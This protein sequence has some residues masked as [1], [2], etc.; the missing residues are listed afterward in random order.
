MGEV[1]DVVAR[2]RAE[3][4]RLESAGS[5][6]R[7]FLGTYLRTT[8]AIGAALRRGL[9]EDPA[10]VGRW[11]AVFADYYLAALAA[12]ER[13]PAAVPRPWR[14]AFGT[15]P[16]VHPVG[17]VL[18]GMNAH[19]NFDLPQ[20]TLDAVPVEAFDDPVLMASRHRDHERVD[21]VL[22]EQV[23]REDVALALDD[24]RGRTVVD[25]ALGP[26]NRALVRRFLRESRRR[27][28]ENTEALHRARVRGP[29][30][31]ADAVRDLDTVSSARVADLAR[32]GP[33]L[34]R[35]AVRGFG[36]TLPPS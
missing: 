20:A 21:R 5:H 19:I 14:L 32:P 16:D 34:V 6:L 11:D 2:M 28:W 8:E 30:H 27:T 35:L 17:H 31:Y 29:E 13:D 25:T 1:D 9:F 33:V 26:A 4:A 18:L 22:A 36:V 3:L 12:H 7:W 24:P 10:W 23:A 15:A